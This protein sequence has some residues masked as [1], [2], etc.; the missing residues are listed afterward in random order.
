M[1]RGFS[2]PGN[3]TLIWWSQIKGLPMSVDKFRELGRE[4][5]RV[6][7]AEQ[8]AARRRGIPVLERLVVE[9]RD[10]VVSPGLEQLEEA[11]RR[12]KQARA[13]PKFEGQRFR[14]SFLLSEGG[15]GADLR[16]LDAGLFLEYELLEMARPLSQ[17]KEARRREMHEN[18]FEFKG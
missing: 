1:C 11:S 10:R 14:T 16:A 5:Y 17:E 9:Y 6:W 8:A 13:T 18:L 15:E 3:L 2:L 7:R 12:L 4:D